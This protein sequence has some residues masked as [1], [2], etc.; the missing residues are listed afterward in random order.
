MDRD[1]HA[2]SQAAAWEDSGTGVQE[3][4]VL[5]AQRVE[6]TYRNGTRA[7]DEV[8]LD[9][10]RG[11]FVSLLGPSGCGKST[12]LKMFAGLE[13][14]SHGHLR[15]WGGNLATVGTP[16]R[17]LAMV[18]QEATLMPWASVEQNARLPLDLRGMPRAE[19]DARVRAALK[20]VGL[21]NFHKVLPRELSGGMQM[22]AS[23]ARALATAPNLLL[24]DE[25][26]GAL[27][28]FTRNKL[29]ADLRDIWSKQDLTVVFVTHSIY[30]A[31]FLSSRVIVMAARPGRVIADVAIDAPGP[32]D[33]AFRL[34]APFMH[35][36]KTLSDY[37]TLAN[38]QGGQHASQH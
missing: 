23:I 14:P 37:L 34:S 20:L 21:E 24:M 31:V 32:R 30:E 27:D 6:K 29:D 36:C 2:M 1:D 19:S 11:E 28:E 13:E 33:D 17:T 35:Y 8:R 38:Q 10:R 26:F 22:R 25:P 5:S 16:E 4:P 15:W 18:F 3:A 9:I 12:L 7:L